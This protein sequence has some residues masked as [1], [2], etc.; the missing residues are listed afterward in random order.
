M[1]VLSV[2]VGRT[3]TCRHAGGEERTA[4][5]KTAVSGRV[6]ARGT[7][8]DGDEVTDTRHH[9]GPDRALLVVSRATYEVFEARLRRPLP[10]GS[11]GEN[12]TVDGTS[13]AEVCVGD[14]LRIG[15]A[16]I[17]ASCPRSPC[18]TLARHLD[19]PGAVEASASPHRAG[20]YARVVAEGEVGAG[21]ELVLLVRPHP[22]ATIR[23]VAAVRRDGADPTTLERL[24]SLPALGGGWPEKLRAKGRPS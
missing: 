15:T 18:G 11:F 23:G 19:D 22:Q 6:W 12:L 20:F 13:E 21:D 10:F 16:V 5:R 4:I 17:E 8:L 2:Q 3:A 9:G 1:R 7:G 24:A 14:R